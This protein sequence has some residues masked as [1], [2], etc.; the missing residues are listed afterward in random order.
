[1][2]REMTTDDEQSEGAEH[3]T[4]IR[5]RW[6]DWN[7][8]NRDWGYHLRMGGID[9]DDADVVH[10]ELTA[11][12]GDDLTP[13]EYLVMEVLAARH[14]LGEATWT[15]PTSLRPAV[16]RLAQ[17]GLVWWKRGVVEHT[18]LVSL[19]NVGRTRWL[20]PATA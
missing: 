12:P 19:T 6:R 11:V 8:A 3:L 4:V 17:R 13:T 1:M 10:D 5:V 2:E 15:F 16:T 20:T 14:R 18:V 7:D 9:V